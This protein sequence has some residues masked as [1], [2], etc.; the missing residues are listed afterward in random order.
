MIISKDFLLKAIPAARVAFSNLDFQSIKS[1]PYDFFESLE[2]KNY[3]VSVDS[4]E[5]S[6]QDLFIALP[7][8]KVNGH[9]FINNALDNGACGFIVE[10]SK[11]E[12]LKNIPQDK[13][14]KK[15][16]IAVPSTNEALLSLA[17]TWRNF[18]NIPIVGITGSVGKT[19]TKEMLKSILQATKMPFC[20]TYKNQNTLIGLCMNILKLSPKDKCGVFELGIQYKGDMDQLADM[21]KPNI[22]IVTHITNAHSLYLGSL[23]EIA[24]EKLKIFKNFKPDNIGIICGDLPVLSNISYSHPVIRFGYKLKNQIH[25]RRI[26]LLFPEKNENIN[27]PQVHFDIKIYGKIISAI[28]NIS[29]QALVKN[30]LAAAT[31]AHVLKCDD[32]SIVKGLANYRPIEGRFEIKKIE[33]NNAIII[34]DCYNANPETM[35]AS[36]LA[37][38]KLVSN[39]RKFAVIGDMLE[40]GDK[41]KFYHRQLGRFIQKLSSINNIIFVGE[42]SKIALQEISS[43]INTNWVSSWADA[44]QIIE[45]ELKNGDLVLIKGSRG[46][47]LL[48]IAKNII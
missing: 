47:G 3:T 2:N 9:D 36:L 44:K 26:K 17:R 30:A 31:A 25:A 22:G 29:N 1:I 43:N 34:N 4:R 12:A 38:D 23:K 10:F 28:L 24:K 41:E 21:L 48:N 11:M 35:K 13:L 7:G 6:S 32:E 5:I 18:F 45:L 39:G 33:S 16:F 14:D 42:R 40:L 37:F 15:I 19:S 8:N 46:V 20:S 27:F